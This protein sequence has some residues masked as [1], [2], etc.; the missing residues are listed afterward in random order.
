MAVPSLPSRQVHL[1]F[2]T[3]EHIPGVGEKFDKKQFQKAVKLGNLNSIT[4]FAKC[5]HSWCYYPTKVGKMHPTLK[6]DLLGEMI[7]ACHEIKVRCPIYITVGWSATDALNHPEWHSLNKDGASVG[8]IKDA[9]PTDPR[10]VF[11]WTMLSIASAY[12]ELVLE[13]TREVV[14]QYDV[15]GIFFDICHHRVD[16]NPV[17]VK[18]MKEAG[19]NLDDMKACERW[20]DTAWVSFMQ[21]ANEII[22]DK[23]PDATIFYNG[24]AEL[25]TPRAMLA[26]D[27]HFE[28]EDLPT[29]WGGYDKF[30]L[31]SKYFA[32]STMPEVQ[33][34]HMLAMSGKFHTAWGEFGGFKHPDAIKFEA[35]SMIAFGARCSMGDQMH[36]SGEMD[37]ETY[38]NIG[39]GYRYVEQIEKF[40]LDARSCSNLGLYASRNHAHD[41]GVSNMLLESQIDYTVISQA[42]TSV[43][44]LAGF[45]TI[46]LT[47][48]QCL[49]QA[50]AD[51]L[52][53]WVKKGGNLIVLGE[54]ALDAEKK[55]FLIDVG[56]EYIGP[57]Q[58]DVDYTVVGKELGS[59]LVKT[60]FLNYKPAH[61]V[62]PVKSAK[63]L[64]TIREPYFSR[65]IEKY[66][67]HQNTA[68]R[69]EIAPH[70]AVI[71]FGKVTYF[72]HALGE[73]YHHNAA[74]V[75]RQLFINAVNRVHKKPI[76]SVTLPSGG[77]YNFVHQPQHKRYV[78]H[79]LYGPPMIRGR[80]QVIEDLVPIA[81]VPVTIR[82]PENVKKAWLPLS[83]KKLTIKKSAGALTVVVPRVQC[84]EV[85]VFEV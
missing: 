23:H 65:T 27:T 24:R 67:S 50:A 2:H 59:E 83:G 74:R 84:H 51:V 56:A 82:V 26:C 62:K 10:P 25:D 61:R 12:R 71:Q 72:A 13:H 48:G 14:N 43:A 4:I 32:G 8:L 55:K 77:R 28:L 18:A 63:V 20:Y 49:N 33:G 39:I 36:P 38:K 40:G 6:F 60:P 76:S 41:S 15:D 54:G 42:P 35:A 73:S 22:R 68:N 30:P 52:S 5:H 1:D 64:A 81:D 7:N 19:V 47:G 78:A 34:K 21:Q 37:L 69:L 46:I 57:G 79:L 80:V 85:V 70:P 3:S 16:F 11:N 66:C 75:H 44:D 9:K 53:A 31:R 29:T 58:F 17:S 45:K